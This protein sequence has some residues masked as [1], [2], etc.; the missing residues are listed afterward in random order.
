MKLR[1]L[2]VLI[3]FLAA[4]GES[5]LPQQPA[6]PLTKDQ[7]MTVVTAGMDNADLAKQIEARGIDF[8]LTDDYLQ[9]LTKAGA[10][11]VVIRALRTVKPSPLGRDQL[12]LLV[13]GGVP[14]ERAAALVKQRGVD[15][16]PD[17]KYLESLRTAGADDTLIA[18][19]SEARPPEVQRHLARAAECEQ[20]HAW[21]EAEK[22]YRAVLALAPGNAEILQKAELAAKHQKPP[23]FKLAKTY[24]HTGNYY[25]CSGSQMPISPDGH[26]AAW[27]HCDGLDIWDMAT[28]EKKASPPGRNTFAFS[29]DGRY[30]A[31]LAKDFKGVGVWELPTGR[32]VSRLP[33]AIALSMQFSPDGKLLAL[34]GMDD[35]TIT[36]WD[37]ASGK[38]VS[39]ATA[40]TEAEGSG[41][42]HRWIYWMAFSPDGRTLASNGDHGT[43]KLRE[44]ATGKDVGGLLTARGSGWSSAVFLPD[45]RWVAAASYQHNGI[46][47]WEAATGKV[48]RSFGVDENRSGDVAITPE[49]DWLAWSSFNGVTLWEVGT[50]R[51]VGKLGG[52]TSLTR[53]ARFSADGKWLAATSGT[54]VYLWQR[55]D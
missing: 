42:T 7:I 29:P 40:L 35:G 30:L 5:A 33:D 43:I 2:T 36:V 53:A 24:S 13:A 10:Q 1:I 37:L 46:T 17:E 20:E 32:E 47:L 55:Q 51:K 16:M 38:K 23:Q 19:V 54:E 11:E 26:W 12:L 48:V 50:G 39:E 6:K 49:G 41:G 52:P 18:V 4:L 34:G 8:D 21:A 14:S 31:A 25:G 28:G 9:A 44:T 15:F 3:V 45:G 22:E 27:S